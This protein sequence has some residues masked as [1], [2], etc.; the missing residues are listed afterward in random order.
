MRDSTRLRALAVGLG[1]IPPRSMQ[2][3]AQAALLGRLAR[4]ARR[5]VEIGI[6]E[7]ASAAVLARALP[8]RHSAPSHRA[9]RQW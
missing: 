6:Y 5:A 3:P 9:A 8:A 7:G 2:D 1:V 4:T